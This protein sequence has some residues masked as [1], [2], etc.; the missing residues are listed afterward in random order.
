VLSSLREEL[1]LQAGWSWVGWNEAANYCLRNDVNMKEGLQWATRSVFMNPNSTNIVTQSRIKAKMAPEGTDA[2]VALV[3]A[4]DKNLQSFQVSWKEYDGMAQYLANNKLD[5]DKALEWASASVDM[6]ATMTN[7]MTK[8]K[9]Y[10]S[11]GKEKEAVVIKNKALELG[12]NPELN[13]YG[14][15]LLFSGKVKEAVEVFEAN[16]K[17][18][19]DDPNVFDSLGEGYVNA[20]YNEKAIKAF[21]KCL[22]MNPPANV[23]ANSIKLLKQLGVEEKTI[24]P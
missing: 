21:K 7:M 17:K 24:R 6:N 19:P 11:L 13:A 16:A 3:E 10:N 4:I 1:Q 9:I 15:Q 12:T 18:N 5:S 14:Y 23:R 2:N 22:S 8:S 20:G